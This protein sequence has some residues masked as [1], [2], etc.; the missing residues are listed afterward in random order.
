M[1]KD[2]FQLKRGIFYFNNLAAIVGLDLKRKSFFMQ[3]SPETIAEDMKLKDLIPEDR[4]REKL[5]LSGAKT[6]T[7]TELIAILLRSGTRQCN[8]ME[9]ARRLLHSANDR[10]ENLASMSIEKIMEIKG[11][12]ENKAITVAAAFEIGRRLCFE[13]RNTERKIISDSLSA[14]SEIVPFLGGLQH[15]E[16]WIMFLNRANH[17]ISKERISS[18]GLSSTVIDSKII[19]KK[20]LEKLASGIILFHNHPSGNPRPGTNDIRETERLKKAAELLGISLLDHIIVASDSYY[21]F[22]EERCIRIG[23]KE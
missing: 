16:C 20:A 2:A 13:E 23:S 5:R 22:A 15:E 6:L 21:S 9:T 11:I 14:F 3:Y 1:E 10:L 8:V 18:G 4:P 12:G 7:S 19:L 17:M